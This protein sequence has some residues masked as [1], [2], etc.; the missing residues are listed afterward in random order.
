MTYILPRHRL[1]VYVASRASIPERSLM[2]RNFRATGRRVNSTWIDEAGEGETGDMGELWERIEREVAM[3]E[4][5]ILY[6][7]SGDLPLKGAF[8][9][10][11][12]AL[13]SDIPVFVVA[14]HMS[15][16]HLRKGI[17][18]WLN[19]PRVRIVPTISAAADYPVRG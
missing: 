8:V 10:V 11:G 1:G 16:N 17:G 13:A 9:E 19:H 3:S 12:M 5:L 6:V 15:T 4:R 2:W 7:D 18:S 14:P